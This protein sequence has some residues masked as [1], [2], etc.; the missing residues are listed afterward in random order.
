MPRKTRRCA[1]FFAGRPLFT[2]ALMNRC[3]LVEFRLVLT[4]ADARKWSSTEP[5]AVRSLGSVMSASVMAAKT[6]GESKYG[7]H[8]QS[9][10]PVAPTRPRSAYPR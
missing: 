4:P 3:H 9:I 2:A 10:D 8:S 1:N 5:H 6:L 7:K